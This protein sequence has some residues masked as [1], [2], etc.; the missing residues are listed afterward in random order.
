M[1]I[2]Q[3]RYFLALCDERTFTSAAQR[4]G[5]SQPTLTTAIRRLEEELG[6]RLFDRGSRKTRLS[7]FGAA[8]R[9]Y[10]LH[11]ERS[12]ANVKREAER[13]QS[14]SSIDPINIRENPM[15]KSIYGASAMAA[16]FLVAAMIT[17]GARQPRLAN[18]SAEIP[19]GST[20]DLRALEDAIDVNA[21]P[22]QDI[23]SEADE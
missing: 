17:M 14:A 21:L 23:L 13:L 15:R 22:R 5:V 20:L 3:I 11:L 2:S 4:C 18:A 9:P 16:L 6:E 12:A 1:Q 10:L 7:P 19:A 8:M